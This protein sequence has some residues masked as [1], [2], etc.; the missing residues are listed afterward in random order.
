MIAKSNPRA[1]N[2]ARSAVWNLGSGSGYGYLLIQRFHMGN[3]GLFVDRPDHLLHSRSH[4]HWIPRRPHDEF[5]LIADAWIDRHVKHGRI[6]EFLHGA[7][8]CAFTTPTISIHW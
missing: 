6:G 8:P 1:A 7:I 4:G 3:R 2:D 5:A